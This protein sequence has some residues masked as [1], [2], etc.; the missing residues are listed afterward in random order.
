MESTSVIVKTDDKINFLA[1]KKVLLDLNYIH[2]YVV[3]PTTLK[4]YISWNQTL[5]YEKV[6][7]YI[8]LCSLCAH[9]STVSAPAPHD[10]SCLVPTPYHI[11]GIN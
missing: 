4:Q 1:A 5:L 9:A 3:L 8:E 10:L 11:Y 7:P 2:L 6:T